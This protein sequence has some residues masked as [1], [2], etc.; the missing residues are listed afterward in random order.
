MKNTAIL[1]IIISAMFAA[2]ENQDKVFPD[3]DYNAVYFPVQ[4]PVRTLNLGY[5]RFDNSM[6]RELRFDIGITIG[7]IYEN[8]EDWTV[9]YV[10]DESLCDSLGND[11]KALPQNYYS[12]SPAADV[13]I[14]SGSFS[15]LIT[16]QLTGAFLAD[17][18]STGNHYVVPLRI[19]ATS[20][21]SILTGLPLL[22]GADK[23]IIS[24][25]DPGAPPKDFTL[26]MI[27]YIN[28]YHGSYLRRGVDFTLDGGGQITDT[29]SYRQKHVEEDQVVKLK[30]G[31]RYELETNF[32]GINTGSENGIRLTVDPGS[33]SIVVDSLPGSS[34]IVPETGSGQFVSDG[35]AWGGKSR[36]AIYL[37]YKYFDGGTQHLVYD[38]L[39]YRDNGIMYEE[40]SPVVLG[41]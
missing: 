10:I 36:N 29:L 17:P 34:Y 5:D 4:Y 20:A 24:Q 28:E 21:D 27:K 14:P 7:G 11:V 6:D 22:A 38:T 12:L 15:G 3:Y 13:T 2:C 32:A 41:P 40:F 23:R 8:K 39:V 9:S 35:D 18:L 1:L 31:G 33:G 26:Y 19:T 25:W 37:N 16:V 30:T